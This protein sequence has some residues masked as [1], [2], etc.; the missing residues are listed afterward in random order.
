MSKPKITLPD[1]YCYDCCKVAPT[2][3]LL[4]LFALSGCGPIMLGWNP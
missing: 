3:F 2:L 4:L 1:W